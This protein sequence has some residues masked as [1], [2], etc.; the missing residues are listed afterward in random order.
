MG[1]HLLED[2]LSEKMLDYDTLNSARTENTAQLS[3]MEMTDKVIT[4][5]KAFKKSKLSSDDLDAVTEE[6]INKRI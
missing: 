2:L 4:E 1:N 5:G 3:L 6:A